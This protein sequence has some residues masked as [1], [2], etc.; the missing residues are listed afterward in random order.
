MV[1][2]AL[3]RLGGLPHRMYSKHMLVKLRRKVTVAPHTLH[4]QYVVLFLIATQKGC[5]YL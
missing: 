5:K 3:E 2:D 4:A 1:I